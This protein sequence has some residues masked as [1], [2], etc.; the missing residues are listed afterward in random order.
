MPSYTFVSSANAF[1]LRGAVPVF[2]DIRKDTLNLDGPKVEHARVFL[3]TMFDEE[4][5]I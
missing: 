1:A 2:V 3:C 4:F 5:L